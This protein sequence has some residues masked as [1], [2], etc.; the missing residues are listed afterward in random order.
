MGHNSNNMGTTWVYHYNKWVVLITIKGYT[1]SKGANIFA[2][3]YA[4]WPS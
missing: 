2:D 3:I 1:S 4:S